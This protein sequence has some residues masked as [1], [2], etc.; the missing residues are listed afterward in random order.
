MNAPMVMAS[1]L[2]LLLWWGF[3][4][5]FAEGLCLIVGYFN[6][7]YSKFPMI[8][9]VF[10]LNIRNTDRRKSGRSFS[11]LVK[12]LVVKVHQKTLCV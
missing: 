2:Y 9:V 1:W 12:L 4:V 10:A 6:N 7:V 11:C 8:Q 3:Y 5:Y